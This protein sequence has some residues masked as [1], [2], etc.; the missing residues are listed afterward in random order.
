M[1]VMPN[2]NLIIVIE[3]KIYLYVIYPH[4]CHYNLV[5]LLTG[6]AQS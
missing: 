2:C 5:I 3:S 4:I 6:Q 1:M